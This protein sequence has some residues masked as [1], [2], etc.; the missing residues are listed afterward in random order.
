M[1]HDRAVLPIIVPAELGASV[2]G[3]ASILDLPFG[4][5]TSLL[6]FTVTRLLGFDLAPIVVAYRGIPENARIPALLEGLDVKLVAGPAGATDL[7]RAKAALEELNAEAA[8]LVDP[9]AAFISGTVL[10]QQMTRHLASR[11]E[12]TLCPMVTR[13][14]AGIGIRKDALARLASARVAESAIDWKV[15][16]FAFV[17]KVAAMFDIEHLKVDDRFTCLPIEL[18]PRTP[19]D[20]RILSRFALPGT[21][22]DYDEVFDAQCN[23]AWT[24]PE[25]IGAPRRVRK[26]GK[27]R[28]LIVH[29]TA[30]RKIG[31]TAALELLL[32]NWDWTRYDGTLVVTTA[33][34]LDEHL[35]G[36]FPV[37]VIPMGLWVEDPYRTPG[38]SWGDDFATASALLADKEP[39]LVMVSATLPP[40]GLACR[41]AGI[42]CVCWLHQPLVSW[43]PEVAGALA[44]RA[45][46]PTYDAVV[47]T[48]QWFE[49]SLRKAFRPPAGRLGMVTCGVPFERFEPSSELREASRRRYGI[50][51]DDRVITQVG[52]LA[53]I[54]RP[55]IAIEALAT[56]LAKIP[57]ALLVL[58]GGERP[59]RYGVKASLERLADSLG[60]R[61]RVRFLGEIEDIESVFAAGDVHLHSGVRET[62]GMVMV[63]AM[64]MKK[65]VVAVDM[66]G[67]SEI[68]VDRE[69]GRLVPPPGAARDLGEAIVEVL[70]DPQWAAQLGE[71]G[72]RRA[73]ERFGVKRFVSNLEAICAKLI[74]R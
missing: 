38:G 50:A 29:Y 45:A 27:P 9:R 58:A 55:E 10:R 6:R 2:D 39:D 8:C 37:E 56:V 69:T 30:R 68:I 49:N 41:A 71:A 32:E 21:T 19:D 22:E 46:L 72:Y 17:W 66:C 28:L 18:T 51:D 16:P 65:P 5:D 23:A 33:G 12:L 43:P 24:R 44:R 4:N 40:L 53:E 14:L 1:L 60:V 7:E 61:E 11:R 25:R 64:A 74:G 63:E 31:S 20:V 57:R 54:K 62:F 70:S 42:P 73:H 36:K 13:G 26:A 67:P 15:D 48:S 52:M 59:S 3:A 34:Q 35:R 47:C